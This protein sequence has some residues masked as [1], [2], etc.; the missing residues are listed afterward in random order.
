[1]TTLI[2]WPS[3][4]DAA[5]QDTESNREKKIKIKMKRSAQLERVRAGLH[6]YIVAEDQNR[7]ERGPQDASNRR[8]REPAERTKR[9]PTHHP[10]A[11]K[12]GNRGGEKG[13]RKRTRE[14]EGEREKKRGR[15]R[16]RERGRGRGQREGGEPAPAQEG[17]R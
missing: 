17:S 12:D 13:E 6:V 9:L 3:K 14:R 8:L 10:R 11:D 5:G 16:K 1:M 2:H 15:E 7:V 4:R